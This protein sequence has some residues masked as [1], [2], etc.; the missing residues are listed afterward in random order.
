MTAG[1]GCAECAALDDST[2]RTRAA[3]P[4][5]RSLLAGGAAAGLL[6]ALGD[7]VTAR[8]AFAAG[9]STPYTGDTLVVLS[10]RGGFDGLSAVA[11]VG[12]PH[13]A[14]L[15]PTIAV[16]PGAALRLDAT[17]ALHP[18]LSGLKSLYD[19]GSLAIVHATGMAGPNRSHFEAMAQ[20]EAAAPGGSVRT[21]WLGRLL[22]LHDPDG[23]F[24]AVQVGGGLPRSL[25]GDVPALAM[26]SVDDFGLDGVGS[27]DLGPWSAF[28]RTSFTHA[29]A[30]L[31]TSARTALG[32]LKT[33]DR[34]HRA[35]YAPSNGAT[36]PG[37]DLGRRLRDV[38]R[39]VRADVGLR[40]ATLDVGDWDMHSGLGRDGGGW[41]RDRLR[42]LD[43][44]V[45][46]FATDLGTDL[47]RVTLV[48]ISEFGR[49]AEEN[50]N[51]G[52]DHGWGNVML[53]LGGHVN[54][55][56]MFGRW[57]GLAPARLTD[58]DLTATTDYRAVLADVL[59]NRAGAS[60]GQV[61]TVFPGWTGSTLGI[62][63]AG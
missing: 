58:G 57:P 4:S 39:L 24:G 13:Y 48:T 52:V 1:R 5:R 10:L 12:D 20:I 45:T 7:T 18:A 14:T 40:V 30:A 26:W 17:F 31:R 37:S 51:G 41:M 50:E 33:T 21:G 36:Y 35:G 49:R 8:T 11:P 29:P 46:A 22:A 15:R 23:P 6:A 25:A 32:A 53:V 2:G 9:T 27:D 63:A 44:A 34:L 43:D 61:S 55:G 60:A 42:E 54:G 28:L 59:R 3:G 19:N 38:A 56:R 47:G 62:T 16:P